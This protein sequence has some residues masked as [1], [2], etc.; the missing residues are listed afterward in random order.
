MMEKR[1]FG[2]KDLADYVGM[3]YRTLYDRTA[4]SA[5]RPFPVKARR[6]GGSLRFDRQEVDRWIDDGCPDPYARG[7]E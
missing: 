7:S 5:K 2:I 6:I 3:S 1:M 4:P